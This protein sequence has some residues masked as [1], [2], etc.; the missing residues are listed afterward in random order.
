MFSRRVL[1]NSTDGEQDLLRAYEYWDRGEL[2]R[3]LKL[4][5]ILTNNGNDTAQ[6]A[7][8]PKAVHSRSWRSI[9]RLDATA[10]ESWST[11]RWF[12]SLQRW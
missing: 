8:V 11:S 7:A 10:T 3:A 1:K 12:P 5:S 2:R 4:F 6:W 9:K